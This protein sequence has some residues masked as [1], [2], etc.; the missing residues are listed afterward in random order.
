[1]SSDI[2]RKTDNRFIITRGILN[3][4][5]FTIKQNNST[6][7]MQIKDGDTFTGYLRSLSDGSV[8]LTKELTVSNAEG[9]IVEL[10]LTSQETDSLDDDRGQKED[11]YYLNPL[12]S[13]LIECETDNNGSFIAKVDWVYVD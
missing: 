1:M 13:L 9:G 6:L 4:F 5:T 12:Y 7:P 11:R 3:T 8:V 2:F 10:T